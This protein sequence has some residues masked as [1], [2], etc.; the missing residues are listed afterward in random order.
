MTRDISSLL[1]ERKD[2]LVEVSE[3][4]K[5]L[6][7]AN[8]TISRIKAGGSC[9]HSLSKTDVKT[10]RIVGKFTSTTSAAKEANIPHTTFS[11]NLKNERI[12]NGFIYKSI[13]T[14]KE[15]VACG[16]LKEKKQFPKVPKTSL[17]NRNK[18]NKCLNK[19]L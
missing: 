13:P 9:N 2:L 4:K 17:N 15:C 16:Q 7:R 8:L 14:I 18:C 11:R 12:M 19:G 3:L 5:Q 10:G 6:K 1:R